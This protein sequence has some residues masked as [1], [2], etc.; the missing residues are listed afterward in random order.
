MVLRMS[1][2]VDD[3]SSVAIPEAFASVPAG[4]RYFSDFLAYLVSFYGVA[5]AAEAARTATATRYGPHDFVV[6]G[7]RVSPAQW[8]WRPY[9]TIA[10]LYSNL[11]PHHLELTR[12]GAAPVSA[13]AEMRFAPALDRLLST[14]G[15]ALGTNYY[16]RHVGDIKRA[17]GNEQNDWPEPWGFAWMVRNAMAHDGQLAIRDTRRPPFRW[18][19]LEYSHLQNG[20]RILHVDLWPGDLFDLIIDLDAALP[21]P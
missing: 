3:S 14:F 18:R 7:C 16:E 13:T 19:G 12:L 15:Q 6:L 10:D 17:Y 4:S 11:P 2:G 20:R 9:D 21:L 8:C 1:V 5:Q